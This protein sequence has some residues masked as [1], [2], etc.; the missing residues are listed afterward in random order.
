MSNQDKQK[1]LRS[2]MVA[3]TA[4]PPERYLVNAT[5][6]NYCI[7]GHFDRLITPVEAA[8]RIARCARVCLGCRYPKSEVQRKR[9]EKWLHD[10]VARVL[11]G[12]A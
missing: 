10:Q 2:I 1:L 8:E 6:M 5:H 12:D 11:E 9:Y 4:V 7:N 3:I